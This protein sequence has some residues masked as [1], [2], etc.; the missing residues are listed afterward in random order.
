[1]HIGAFACRFEQGALR[2]PEMFEAEQAGYWFSCGVLD[3]GSKYA[4][5]RSRSKGG[6][7]QTFTNVFRSLKKPVSHVRDGALHLP[8]RYR[9]WFSDGQSLAVMGAGRNFLVQETDKPVI[10]QALPGGKITV[11]AVGETACR[12]LRDFPQQAMPLDCSCVP[13]IRP[14]ALHNRLFCT[15]AAVEP[16]GSL[17]DTFLSFSDLLEESDSVDPDT[18][19]RVSGPKRALASALQDTGILV[20]V[21]CIDTRADAFDAVEVQK[22]AAEK[23]VPSIVIVIAP[24]LK[25]DDDNKTSNEVLRRIKA[26]NAKGC[27][28]VIRHDDKKDAEV[29]FAA[30]DCDYRKIRPAKTPE[31]S[32]QS[33]MVYALAA[34]LLPF[35]QNRRFLTNS[36][37]PK[38]VLLSRGTFKLSVSFE[39]KPEATKEDNPEPIRIPSFVP[40]SYVA[41]FEGMP[42]KDNAD[43]SDIISPAESLPFA[44][45]RAEWS[46]LGKKDLIIQLL[47]M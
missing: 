18:G 21:T 10:W 3:N 19:T 42:A 15:G 34:V 5:L 39:T 32:W 17:N 30:H 11:A 37:S 31:E 43:E 41:V 13:S 4:S 9:D 23:G 7:M 45:C 2:L 40:G 24:P 1:M 29:P 28:V 44:Y 38:N 47:P 36:I 25:N 6:R 35:Q 27:M 16:T 33:M 12:L 46:P 8:K 14:S 20:L 26:V 22:V